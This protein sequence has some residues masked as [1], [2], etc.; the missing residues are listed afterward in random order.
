MTTKMRKWFYSFACLA[1]VMAFLL[2]VRA[3]AESDMHDIIIIEPVPEGIQSDSREQIDDNGEK[4]PEIVEADRCN[5]NEA[6][7]IPPAKK[8]AENKNAEVEI[9]YNF[10]EIKE[11]KEIIPLPAAPEI[12]KKKIREPPK[13]AEKKSVEKDPVKPAAVKTEV[14]ENI[15]KKSS[16]P[17]RAA[18][19]VS[20]VCRWKE[21]FEPDGHLNGVTFVDDWN[22]EGGVIFT[23][24]T[25]FYLRQD[26]NAGSGS[27]LVIE[28]K[29]SSAVFACD[30]SGKVDLNKTPV[31]RWR[32][33]VK[34]LPPFADGRHRKKDDQAVGIYIGTGTAFNQKAISYRWETETPIGHWGKT[35]YSSVMNVWFLCQRN[36]HSGL[37]VW[38]EESRNVRQDFLDH[39]GFVPENFALGICGNSQNSQSDAL[40]EID[41]IGFY[42][43][44]KK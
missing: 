25:N 26:K 37:D 27:V 23:P 36:K 2:L 33:R 20:Y 17:A 16:S 10:T 3:F 34:K 42:E 13:T 1:F 12:N 4:K 43:E 40:A 21:D 7:R 11:K 35:V 15:E 38:Y 6:L 31:L 30:L 5:E 18:K 22:R 41:Y 32:W 29:K 8:Y 44:I 19:K 14:R 9:S 28:S 24:K 39:Y